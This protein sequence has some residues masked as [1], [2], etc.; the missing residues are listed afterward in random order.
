MINITTQQRHLMTYASLSLLILPSF[1]NA[2]IA[3]L[4]YENINQNIFLFSGCFNVLLL[5]YNR[6]T[7]NMSQKNFIKKPVSLATEKIFQHQKKCR[8]AEL[9]HAVAYCRENNCRGYKALRDPNYTYLF[10][11]SPLT[12]NNALDGKV[13]PGELVYAIYH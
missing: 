5:K 1:A 2:N 6:Y 7:S 13:C 11:K 8:R 10:L 4:Y 9:Q 3:L 12:I